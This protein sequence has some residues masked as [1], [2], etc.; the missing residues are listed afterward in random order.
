MTVETKDRAAAA[1]KSLGE[2]FTRDVLVGVPSNKT[3]RDEPGD[4]INN[5]TIGYIMENGAPEANI[6]A[7]PHL[8]P[9]IR[10]AESKFVPQLEKAAQAAIDGNPQEMDRRLA[11]AGQIAVNEVKEVI[12]EGV[13][14]ALADSTVAARARRGRKGAQQ[15]LANRAAGMEPA[16]DLAKPLV[17]TAQYLNSQTY[18]VRK[19]RPKK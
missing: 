18:V 1:M 19:G 16:L 6:P 12:R 3:E 11:M 13:A 17:D 9:G 10:R 15:E 14:P 7:R 2:L 8:V 5:A 4:P